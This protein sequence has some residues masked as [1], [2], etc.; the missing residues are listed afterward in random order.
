MSP[1]ELLG[2]FAEAADAQAAAVA[3]LRGAERRRTTDRPGQFV[4]DLVA[5]EAVL[6]VLHRRPIAVLSEESGRSGVPDAAI[7]V[8]VDPVDGSTNCARDLPYWAISLCALDA[9]GP[10][11]ALVANQATGARVTAVRGEGAWRDGERLATSGLTALPQAVVALAGAPRRVLPWHQYRAM[12]SA[13]LELCEV[14][15]GGLDAFVDAGGRLGPWDYLGGLLACREAG[16]AIVDARG[17]DLVVSDH[18]ARRQI[19]AAA[20]LELLDAVRA[21]VAP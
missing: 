18:D 14:A 3:P 20:S 12:G 11:C 10:L 13:A 15:A 7:T 9:A 4:L 6:R 5:D 21:A 8:V 19:L 17:R 16:A 1:D 2:L